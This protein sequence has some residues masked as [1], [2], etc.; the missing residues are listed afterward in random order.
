MSW[1]DDLASLAKWAIQTEDLR[2]RFLYASSAA[3]L[4]HTPGI[5]QALETSVVLSIYEAARRMRYEA[6]KTVAYERPYPGNRRGNPKKAD[7]AFKDKG[8]GKNWAYVEVKYY[9]TSGKA[10]IRADIDKLKGIKQRSQRWVLCYRVRAQRT[11]KRKGKRVAK[12][13]ELLDKNFKNELTVLLK[14]S[15]S[16]IGD[17]AD[18]AVCDIVLARVR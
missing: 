7:L 11:G 14:K 4:E 12:L 16:T 6:D 9:G 5:T 8:R 10:A 13:D 1:S 15:V 2:H 18:P 3:D 17:D